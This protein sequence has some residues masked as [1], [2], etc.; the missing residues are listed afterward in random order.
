MHAN[1]NFY[2]IILA[3]IVLCIGQFI[4]ST[5]MNVCVREGVAMVTNCRVRISVYLAL[6]FHIQCSLL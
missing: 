2:E 3:F 5:H 4:C 1:C 6:I